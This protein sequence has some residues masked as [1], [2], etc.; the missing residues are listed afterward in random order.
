MVV[1]IL[2][3]DSYS[4]NNYKIIFELEQLTPSRY[5]KRKESIYSPNRIQELT[6][7]NLCQ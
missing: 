3:H 4:L 5:S 1:R 6:E 7:H 2:S